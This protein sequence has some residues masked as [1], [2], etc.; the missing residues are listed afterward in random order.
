MAA[1]ACTRDLGRAWRISEEL[2][3]GMVGIN[4]GAISYDIV[5]FGGVKESGIG[6]EGGSYGIEEYQEIKYINMGLGRK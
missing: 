2:E 6:R 1:Y 5:P 3:S 4:E